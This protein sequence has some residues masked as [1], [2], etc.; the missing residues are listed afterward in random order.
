MRPF[1]P[2][3]L[4]LVFPA[5][6]RA[7]AIPVPLAP[8][9]PTTTLTFSAP[10][11][12]L[13]TCAPATLEWSSDAPVT[14]TRV[15]V[16]SSDSKFT[17]TTVKQVVNTTQTFKWDAVNVPAGTY[18]LSGETE[19]ADVHI[20]PSKPFVVAAG[21]SLSCIPADST[22]PAAQ[23]SSATPSPTPSSSGLS[24]GAIAGILLCVALVLVAAGAFFWHRTVSA[25]EHAHK[26]YPSPRPSMPDRRDSDSTVVDIVGRAPTPLGMAMLS[27]KDSKPLDAE[28]TQKVLRAL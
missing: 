1:V 18:T 17:I 11:T 26:Q 2:A 12:D 23:S 3:V 9:A 25:R 10:A 7:V 14:I 27:R 15:F 16:N 20:L 8:R 24:T 21:S 22:S 4:S 6:A 5:L 28:E 13:S 19:P